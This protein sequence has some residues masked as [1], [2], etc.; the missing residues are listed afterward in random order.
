MPGPEEGGQG[1]YEWFE[2][3]FA[4]AAY[5]SVHHR[6]LTEPLI[7]LRVVSPVDKTGRAPSTSSWGCG[8]TWMLMTSPTLR[9]AAAPASTA[10]FTAPTSPRTIAVTR[11]AS[12]F[13]Q[14]TSMTLADFTAA[15]AASIIA[16]SPR[17]SIIPSAFML[18]LPDN[19]KSGQR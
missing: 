18:N 16:T 8:I 5:R 15:S 17:H 10:L 1:N 12:I 11:P 3:R 6:G 4:G 7:F 14:P 13:S 2:T 19:R 9:P